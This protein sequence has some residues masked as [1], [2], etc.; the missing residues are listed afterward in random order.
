MK[1][2]KEIKNKKKQFKKASGITLI[3]LVITIVVLIVLATI[4]ITLTL[5][6]GGIFGTAETAKQMQEMAGIKEEADLVKN[7]LITKSY[8]EE[9]VEFNKY[10][11]LQA[12]KDHFNGTIDGD[13]VIVKDG[14]YEII[15]DDNLNITVQKHEEKQTV[16]GDVKLT[17]T[18]SGD[19]PSKTIRLKIELLGIPKKADSIESFYTYLEEEYLPGKTA[20]ELMIMGG[21]LMY[22][23]AP[24]TERMVYDEV[25]K[26]EF[27]GIDYD[28]FMA[29]KDNITKE[30]K[31]F[32]TAS[33]YIKYYIL[34][35]FIGDLY[36]FIEDASDL[37]Y[38][39]QLLPELVEK[40]EPDL[41]GI[42]EGY[43]NNEKTFEQIV[44][45]V[46]GKTTIEE[47]ILELNQNVNIDAEVAKF[48]TKEQAMILIAGKAH[49]VEITYPDGRTESITDWYGSTT[50]T[51]SYKITE[52]GSYTFKVKGPSGN[53]E[54]ITYTIGSLTLDKNEILEYII[55]EEYSKKETITA[56]LTNLNEKDLKWTTSDSTIAEIQGEG[57]TV[58]VIPKSGGEAII[59]ATCGGYSAS[60]KVEIDAW[61][62]SKVDAVKSEDN[63]YVPVPNGY[64]ASTIAGEKS[65]STGF[66]IKKGDNG[67]ATSGVNEFVWVPVSDESFNEMFET[68]TTGPIYLSG[69]SGDT[70]VKTEYY[71]KLRGTTFSKPGISKGYREPDLV[72]DCDIDYYAVQAGYTN[73]ATMAQGFVDDYKNMRESIQKYNGFYIGRYELTGSA[74]NPTVQSGP[75]LTAESAGKWY[76]LYKACRKVAK[77]G[78]TV[79]STMIWGCQ[80]DET[81]NWLKNTKFK[82][83]TAAVDSNSS[84]WGNYSNSS[85]NA[86]LKDANGK[87]AYGSPQITGYSKEYWSANNVCDLA[88]NYYDWTQEAWYDKTRIVRG[89]DYDNAGSSSPASER[90][91]IYDSACYYY[92]SSHLSTRTT[93]YVN[94]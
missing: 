24:I 51:R 64:V 87:N 6:D 79:T 73:L 26:T 81:M 50:I 5:K 82:N 37:V 33:S 69:Q 74:D 46:T 75:V 68:S 10:T 42:I 11:L 78:E 3:A 25:L 44:T 27:D 36:T 20:E 62:L 91:N 60:C 32:P 84:S 57:T 80:W 54:K 48:F 85:D 67:A 58:T 47:Y 23:G 45:E 9:G 18:E 53:T 89:G 12:L 52:Y 19:I 22:P 34:Q 83:N 66:V 40:N 16:K 92:D 8:T 30:K 63:Q 31:N 86:A 14:K 77:Q 49:G 4:S 41:K 28:T 70:G 7:D 55:G 15:V 61:D 94:P 65:V 17:Y 71:S 59:T 29:D 39:K 1:K 88:G 35:G 2:Q 93:L 38:V 90:W 43:Y 56:T 76:G 13:K 72:V 21:Q